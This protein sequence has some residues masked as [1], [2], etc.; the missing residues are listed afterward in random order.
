MLF[1]S[2]PTLC[3]YVDTEVTSMIN[4]L[5]PSIVAHCKR[6]KLGSEKRK[7]SQLKEHMVASFPG[8]EEGEEKDQCLGMRLILFPCP[9]Q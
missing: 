1:Q 4:A 9:E 5:R 6:Q 8:P 7:N 2:F 3:T